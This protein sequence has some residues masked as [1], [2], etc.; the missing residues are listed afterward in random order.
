MLVDAQVY[1]GQIYICL[2]RSFSVHIRELNGTMF[3]K[4]AKYEKKTIMDRK[5]AHHIR[6]HFCSEQIGQHQNK[7]ETINLFS[8]VQNH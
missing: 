1:I 3:N 7:R 8:P 5:I 2:F 6:R 4:F